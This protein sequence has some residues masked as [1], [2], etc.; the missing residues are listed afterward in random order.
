MDYTISRTNKVQKF[1]GYIKFKN[2]TEKI[3]RKNDYEKVILLSGNVAVLLSE[4]LGRKYIKKYLIDIRDYFKENNKRYFKAEE[5]VIDNC[6][7][8]VISSEGYKAFLPKHDYIL[9]HNAPD[10]DVAT[11]EKIRVSIR[12]RRANRGNSPIVLS[13]IG[14]VRFLE[15]DK[16][17][18]KYFGNDKRFQIRYIGIGANNLSQY[19]ERQEFSNVYLHDKFPPEKTLDYFSSTDAIINLYGSGT[20]LL[21]HALSNKLYY[22]ALL[23]VPILVCPET[24]MSKISKEYNFGFDIDLNDPVIKDEFYLWYNNVDESKLVNGC[25]EFILKYNK[26]E[27]I[28]NNSISQ[29]LNN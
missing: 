3:L 12:Y 15:Q 11:R 9:A 13:F 10:I 26:E 22:A 6:A 29:W 8:A 24:F 17:I 28:F 25:D 4:V 2:F 16:R 27:E 19:V 7:L 14:G 18:L 1:I 20:P 23:T 21:D 5:K